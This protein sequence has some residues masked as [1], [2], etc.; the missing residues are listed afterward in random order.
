MKRIKYIITAFA[1]SL[2]VFSCEKQQT[3]ESGQ[4]NWP[5]FLGYMQFSTNV[6]TKAALAT[7]MHDKSFGVIGYQYAT[8][9]NWETAKALAKPTTF[10][11]Q[12]VKCAGNGVCSYDIN[13]SETGD[14]LKSW[15]EYLYTFFAYQPYNGAGISLS[16]SD[17]VNTP[18]LTYTYGWLNEGIAPTTIINA[19]DNSNIF[20]LMTAEAIDVNGSG[21]GAVDLEFKHRLFAVEVIA[22][23]FNEN[24][25]N[26]TDAR[27]VINNLKLAISGLKN[28]KMTIPISMIGEA[29]P[30]Y[31]E[32]E[33]NKVTFQISN[34][35]VII[36]AFNETITDD[37][38]GETRGAGVGS[39]ISR[40]G[41][42]KGGYLMFIPQKKG[43]TFEFDWDE[44]AAIKENNQS[45][46]LQTSFN[47]DMEFKAG[48]LYQIIINFVGDGITIAIIEAGSWDQHS[49]YHTFE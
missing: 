10:Y 12:E 5:I 23:N 28:I 3:P 32:G 43:L 40:L 19:Y 47:S 33:M 16:G 11:N 22:N 35:E 31:N 36:P 29:D 49:V 37:A 25:E 48:L 9:T 1:V 46:Q 30:T 7:D 4:T 2:L 15:E 26:T 42:D 18:I 44:L 34:K 6:A 45:S 8:T 17:V 38:T 20:D 24:T 41:S 39:S 27:Q 14:Q 21:S 13:E